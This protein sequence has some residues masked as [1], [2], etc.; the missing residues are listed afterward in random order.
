MYQPLR[1]LVRT[2]GA[3]LTLM[4]EAPA[5]LVAF[6][7]A[8][9]F[10]KFRSFTLECIAF[11]ATWYVLSWLAWLVAGGGRREDSPRA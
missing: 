11:L 8:E 2:R 6:V 1:D 10:F 5:F 7:I 9:F 4:R 3:R